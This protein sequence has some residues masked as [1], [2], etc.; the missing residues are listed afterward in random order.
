MTTFV[1][2]PATGPMVTISAPATEAPANPRAARLDRMR[3]F[4]SGTSAGPTREGTTA[5]SAG[6]NTVLNAETTK[7]APRNTQR[8]NPHTSRSRTR[9]AIVAARTRSEMTISQRRSYRSTSVPPIRLN[10]IPAASDAVASAATSRVEPVRSATIQI[11]QT[12][13]MTLP[14]T[15]PKP[16]VNT[17]T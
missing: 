2:N 7:L 9:R 6:L 4:A 12:P 8:L 3:P 1:A 16:A 5:C 17:R 13:A 11:V 15:E 10:R 14:A